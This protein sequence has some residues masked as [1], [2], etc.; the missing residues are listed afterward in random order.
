MLALKIDKKSI[1]TGSA[2]K[3]DFFD[4]R[5][6]EN[7]K[8]K[9]P[10]DQKNIKNRSNMGSENNTKWNIPWSRKK[11]PLEAHLGHI[12]EPSWGQL[13]PNLAQ[14]GSNLDK[15]WSQLG[16][17]WYQNLTKMN[18]KRYFWR[19]QAMFSFVLIFDLMLA[20]FFQ[21]FRKAAIA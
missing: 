15:F 6:S 18:F 13:G 21:F 14:L 1:S 11:T 17:T 16:P 8:I 3:S 4:S 10:R 19:L 12:L 20:S 2:E 7:I 9:V 5:L